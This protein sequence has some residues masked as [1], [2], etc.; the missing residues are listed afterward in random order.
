MPSVEFWVAGHYWI[1][2][3][4]AGS[5]NLMEVAEMKAEKDLHGAKVCGRRGNG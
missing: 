5:E 1:C 2:S 3:S 4:S